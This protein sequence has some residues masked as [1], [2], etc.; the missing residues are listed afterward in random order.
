M[1][2]VRAEPD[3]ASNPERD[4]LFHQPVRTSDAPT[5]LGRAA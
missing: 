5:V 1:L 4:R 3:E 2:M